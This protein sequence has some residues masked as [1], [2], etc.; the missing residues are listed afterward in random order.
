MVLE[1]CLQLTRLEAVDSEDCCLAVD[2]VDYYLV[3]DLED[4]YLV[5]DWEDYYLVVDWEDYYLAVD[6]GDY[7][8]VVAGIVGIVYPCLVLCLGF[9]SPEL[10]LV[11]QVLLVVRLD[12]LVGR[13]DHLVPLG[14]WVPFAALPLISAVVAAL[15]GA[16]VSLAGVQLVVGLVVPAVL[17]VGVPGEQVGLLEEPVGALVLSEEPLAQL[18]LRGGGLLLVFPVLLPV[19]VDFS[20]ES[21]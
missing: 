14:H 3:V 7:Y 8:L 20:L 18:V 13:L 19:M 6:L 9:P 1:H 16:L 11:L 12:C 21:D 2:L 5:V 15:P 4:Y 17:L 10:F